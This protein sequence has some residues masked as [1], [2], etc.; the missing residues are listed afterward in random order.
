VYTL[1]SVNQSWDGKMNNGNQATEGTY[2]FILKA[3]GADGKNYD[4]QGTIT[5]VK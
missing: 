3:V 1:G 5:L 2:Y 4:R